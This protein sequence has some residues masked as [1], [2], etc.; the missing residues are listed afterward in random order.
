[1]TNRLEFESEL[2]KEHKFVMPQKIA[3]VTFLLFYHTVPED[4]PITLRLHYENND[5]VLHEQVAYDEHDI[6]ILQ[7][8]ADGTLELQPN[9]HPLNIRRAELTAATEAT[10]RSW[11]VPFGHLS[12]AKYYNF[13]SRDLGR[14][15]QYAKSDKNMAPEL[16]ETYFQMIHGRDKIGLRNIRREIDAFDSQSTPNVL[17]TAGLSHIGMAN[18]FR[19]AAEQ[20]DNGTGVDIV[21]SYENLPL[22]ALT[23]FVI[24]KYTNNVDYDRSYDNFMNDESN[25]E[26]LPGD[27]PSHLV[28]L[29]E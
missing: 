26:R 16:F 3:N 5:L 14:M 19:L 20:A 27:T 17:V 2:L 23:R 9:E 12:A 10:Q 15:I 18:T 13:F 28:N 7:K 22:G 11:D 29:T 4:L 8:I 6:E 25:A 21:T 24:D 1:M